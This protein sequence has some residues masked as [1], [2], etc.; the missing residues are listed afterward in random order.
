MGS[1]SDNNYPP[2]A[3]IQGRA[4][5]IRL[6]TDSYDLGVFG[7]YL[8]PSSRKQ[9]SEIATQVMQFAEGECDK[10]ATR[11][12]PIL[13]GDVHSD[14]G[15]HRGCDGVVVKS[16]GRHVGGAQVLQWTCGSKQKP[17]E[18]SPLLAKNNDP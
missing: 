4:A 11:T 15:L 17:Q 2:T 6:Q 13:C 12:T 8:A 1:G 5:G 16:E 10:L 18:S 9:H 3:N 7:I 14:F